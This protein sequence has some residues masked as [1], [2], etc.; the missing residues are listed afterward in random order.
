MFEYQTLIK[1][2]ILKSNFD[3]TLI[4]KINFDQNFDKTLTVEIKVLSE[5]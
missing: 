2:L 5:L 3:K 1:T 4:M